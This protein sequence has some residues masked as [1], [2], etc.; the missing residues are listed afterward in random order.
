MRAFGTTTDLMLH[1]VKGVD[2]LLPLKVGGAFMDM[3]TG[4]S[5][6][7]IELA[8]RRAHK[9]DKVVWLSP[10][11]LKATVRGEIR[12]HTTCT[13][14]D[15]CVFDDKIHS[16]SIPA[17]QWYLVGIES[18][19][20]SDR[21]ALALHQLITPDSFVIL[22]ESA[23]C[24]SPHAKRTERITEYAKDSRYRLAMTGTPVSQGAEDL[25]AQMRFLS[26][27]I[28]GYN[29]FYSF[30]ANHL[31]YSDR[32]PGQVVRAHNEE[33]LAAK[34]APYV[35]QVTKAECLDLPKK[36]YETHY[37]EIT[38]EQKEQYQY[39]KDRFERMLD[40]YEQIPSYAIFNLLLS[41]QKVVSGYYKRRS[42]QI[43][44]LKNN[45]VDALLDVIERIPDD[46]KVVIWVKFH[47]D[48]EQIGARLE[49]RYGAGSVAYYHGGLNETQKDA[50]VSS[51]YGPARFFLGTRSTGGH[52]LT[53]VNASYCI[54]YNK[55]YKY[56]EQLQA[57][58]RLHRI[59]QS[60]PVTIID[61]YAPN[62]ID[63]H[64]EQSL[65]RKGH[66]ARTLQTELRSA[67][68]ERRKELIQAL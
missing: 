11:S 4:K 50:S 66:F 25:Y 19:S 23:Y 40:R 16:G 30:A 68:K 13:D 7:A 34:M 35:Y 9:I 36:I 32:F 21:V 65:A 20:G 54:D 59:G 64:I 26:P 31:E 2:W 15:I 33:Y 45:R 8:K 61:L 53:L 67:E 51:F 56:T 43:V 55:Q 47:Y 14:Q 62:T 41:L 46:E 44:H 57:E 48:I 49:A 24:K 37:V 29:S 1:Q 39:Y 17:A 60:N 28:L 6:L 3:G 42:G 22:D 38:E 27:K 12:K 10:V 18:V 5:R 63:K 58:D 52:G